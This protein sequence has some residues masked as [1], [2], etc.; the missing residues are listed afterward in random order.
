VRS[1]ANVVPLTLF[2]V[3]IQ[4]VAYSMRRLPPG[5]KKVVVGLVQGVSRVRRGPP[6]LPVPPYGP[7]EHIPL[8]GFHL[9]DAIRSGRVRLAPGIRAFTGN[10][11]TF[12]DGSH[13]EFDDVILATGFQ[14]ALQPIAP[15]VRVDGAGF[16][17][18]RDRVAS[19]DRADLF[20]V[21]HNYDSTGGIMNIA[22][23]APLVAQ[24]IAGNG[25]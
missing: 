9:V 5:G 14:P 6:V 21:G 23:D 24:H 19:A 22:K 8:I 13:T 10:G 20:F 15:F 16:A 4:Y 17:L 11:V 3:P 18:R 1:G 25:R 2:G 12:T 7:L